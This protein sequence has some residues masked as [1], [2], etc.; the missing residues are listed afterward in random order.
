MSLVKQTNM[1]NNTHYHEFE[2]D[3]TEI[4]EIELE[5]TYGEAAGLVEANYDEVL[6][7][8]YEGQPARQIAEWIIKREA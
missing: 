2:T 6:A 4:L 1:N 8:Y 7:A 5:C 3:V